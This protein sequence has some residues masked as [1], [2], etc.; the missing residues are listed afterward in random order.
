MHFFSALFLGLG[1]VLCTLQPFGMALPLTRRAVSISLKSESA[2]CSFLPPHAGDDVGGTEENGIP[3]C[4]TSGLSSSNRVFPSGFI[5]SAH[6]ASTSAYVQVTGRMDRSKYSLKASDGGGQY[7]NRD[8]DNVVCNE[9]KYFVN[10][11]EPDNGQYCIRCC[12][13]QSDCHLGESEKGCE[14]II[15]G[16]Y[17]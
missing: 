10:M 3:F 13:S 4:S 8:I 5:E 9:Y 6:Y 2:F 7:D 14:T 15:P 11:L 16:D 12:Q 1:L 17:S